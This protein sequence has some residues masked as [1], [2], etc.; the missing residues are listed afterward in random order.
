MSSLVV[1]RF[2]GLFPAAIAVVALGAI[3]GVQ[4]YAPG[5]ARLGDRFSEENG[6]QLTQSEAEREE[7][8]LAANLEILKN[9]P[10]LGF[11][12]LLANWVFLNFLQYFGDR[13]ARNLTGFQLNDNFFDVISRLDPRWIDMYLFL[14][15]AVGYYQA[16]PE[17][18]VELMG[19]GTRALSPEFPGAWRLWRLKSL[20]ELLLLGDIPA[21]VESLETASEWAQASGYEPAANLFRDAANTLRDNPDSVPIRINA[22][23]TVY[24]QTM[25]TLVR[26][27]ALTELEALGVEIQEGEDGELRFFVPPRPEAEN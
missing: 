20:D 13:E 23:L 15:T 3:I 1:K 10:S 22:W 24:S 7:Q 19:R 11:D 18:S 4:I 9:L 2:E 26:E 25:D 21:A 5:G 17:L 14:S 16:Q 8:R 6:P 12:N 27:R